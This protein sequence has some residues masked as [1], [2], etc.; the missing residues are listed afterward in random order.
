MNNV[1]L[2]GNIGKDPEINTSTGVK[3]ATLTLA[4]TRRDKN[5]TTDWHTIILFDKAADIVEQYAHKGD[6]IAVEGSVQY[7]KVEKDGKTQYFTKIVGN[8]IELLTKREG[9]KP[10]EIDDLPY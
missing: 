7:S 10:N 2:I 3:I 6:K 8:R 1:V 9:N 5:K 4:T